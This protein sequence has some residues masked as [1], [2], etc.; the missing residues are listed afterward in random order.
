MLRLRLRLGRLLLIGGIVGALGVFAAPAMA[1]TAARATLGPTGG[2]RVSG[3]STLAAQGNQTMVTVRISGAPTNSTH[4]NHIHVGSCEA[5]GAVVYPLIDLRTDA[6]GNATASTMV[7]A[8][9]T[10]IVG[11]GHYVNVHAGAALPSPGV[12]CG[13]IVAGVG[14]LPATGGAP[15]AQGVPAAAGLA[16]ALAGATLVGLRR[17]RR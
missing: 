8:S 17:R 11:G 3:A 13:N 4:V 12:S 6:Q 15:L 1:Q 14:T 2:S 10:A 7:N 16:V 5:E 9:L